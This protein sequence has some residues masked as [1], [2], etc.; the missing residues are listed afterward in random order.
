MSNIKENLLASKRSTRILTSNISKSLDFDDDQKFERTEK[1]SD[2][3]GNLLKSRCSQVTLWIIIA[4]VIVAAIILLFYLRIPQKL[5]LPSTPNVQLKDCV[6]KDLQDAVELI[7][8]RGGSINPVNS[9]MYSGEK[10]EYLCYT[11]QYYKTCV[12]QQP[13]LKQHVE[14]EILEYIK[15]TVKECTNTLKENLR[16]KGYNIGEGKQDVSVEIEPNDI[17]IIVSGFSVV[18]EDTAEKYDKFTITEKSKIYDLI[19]LTTSILNWEARY[20]DSDITTYMIYYPNIKLEKYKQED[21]SKI[22]RITDRNTQEKFV[23]ATR[24]LSWPAGYGFGQTF[25]PI[26]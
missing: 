15:P 7:S 21:G 16:S 14:R 4:I 26:S 19:M 24:S 23:F 12:M 3:K 11:N 6:E 10:V 18:K 25:K 13:L 5:L 9:I 20:G 1:I 17:K 22:Y 2:I 8:L